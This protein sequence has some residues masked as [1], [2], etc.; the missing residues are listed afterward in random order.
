MADLQSRQQRLE[1]REQAVKAA[2]DAINEKIRRFK[3]AVL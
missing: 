1:K 3:E 2:E